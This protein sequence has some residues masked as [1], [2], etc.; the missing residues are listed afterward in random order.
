MHRNF[1][2]ERKS[3]YFYVQRKT[4]EGSRGGSP[5]FIKKLELFK[6]WLVV[7][8]VTTTAHLEM[9]KN[10]HVVSYLIKIN[11]W[12]VGKKKPPIYSEFFFSHQFSSSKSGLKK[13]ASI[14]VTH[15]FGGPSYLAK[16]IFMDK[17][18]FFSDE[19]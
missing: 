13:H 18:S 9:I 12:K 15:L 11:I 5:S 19:G 10:M 17:S 8:N 1:I 3:I 16:A 6:K 14:K 2:L 4:K 7:F